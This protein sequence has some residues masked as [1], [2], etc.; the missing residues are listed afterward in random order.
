MQKIA[1]FD[2]EGKH[3]VCNGLVEID[4]DG[5]LEFSTLELLEGEQL[6]PFEINATDWATG[7]KLTPEDA[8]IDI[9]GRYSRN[10]SFDASG[11]RLQYLDDV[12]IKYCCDAKEGV[13][14]TYDGRDIP[15]YIYYGSNLWKYELLTATD[16]YL[17]YA[18]DDQMLM[19]NTVTGATIA[20]NYFATVGEENSRERIECG[21]EKRLAFR[22]LNLDMWE[23]FPWLYYDVVIDNALTRQTHFTFS[24]FIDAVQNGTLESVLSAPIS[25]VYYRCEPI[26]TCK[27]VSELY[28]Y[29]LKLRN[30]YHDEH[31]DEHNAK[32]KGAKNEDSR[33]KGECN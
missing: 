19:F 16:S 25:D 11:F 29:F 22:V 3:F 8:I 23:Y 14:L 30:E 7:Q 9:I 27:T 13:A 33:M 1:E 2:L 28:A 20:D 12:I 32:T 21:I 17:Y 15:Y 10:E 24:D 31:N 18:Y 6:Q 4:E 26:T 5:E